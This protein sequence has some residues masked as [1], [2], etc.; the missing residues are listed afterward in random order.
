MGQ[1][2]EEADRRIL[3]ELPSHLFNGTVESHAN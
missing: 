2:W 3:M 1:I